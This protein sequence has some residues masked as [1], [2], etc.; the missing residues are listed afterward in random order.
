MKPKS[1][2]S[3]SKSQQGSWS[4]LDRVQTKLE[5]LYETEQGGSVF[6][7]VTLRALSLA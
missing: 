2:V 6:L 1:M 5:S 4:W 7:Q 3:G